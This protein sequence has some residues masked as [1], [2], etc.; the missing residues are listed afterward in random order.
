MRHVF[1]L[2]AVDLQKGERWYLLR[3]PKNRTITDAIVCSYANADYALAY[4]LRRYTIAHSLS[5]AKFFS[6]IVDSYDVA[7][8]YYVHLKSRFEKNFCDLADVVDLIR[9]FVPKKHLDGHKE[10]CKYRFSLNYAKGVG[11][12]HGEGIETSWAEAKQSG[13]ST[14]QMNHGHPHECSDWSLKQL[15]LWEITGSWCA[16]K[17]NFQHSTNIQLLY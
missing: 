9:L 17:T 1:F 10:N 5:R 4:A 11:R 7:C 12:G 13:G 8:Q 15:E 16:W 2:S 14:R 3:A 6:H